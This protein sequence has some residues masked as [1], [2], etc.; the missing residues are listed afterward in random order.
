MSLQAMAH[1]ANVP[2]VDIQRSR[3]ERPKNHKFTGNVGDLIPVYVDPDSMPGDTVTMDTSKVIRFQTMLSPV[4][5]NAFMDF[6]WFFCTNFNKFNQ[7]FIIHS[8]LI[9][10]TNRITRINTKTLNNNT[11]KLINRPHFQS[12]PFF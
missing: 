9:L 7:T 11:R 6:F 1:F 2:G 12:L 3:F 4:E 5:G 10:N 8:R